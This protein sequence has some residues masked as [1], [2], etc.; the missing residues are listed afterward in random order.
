MVVAGCSPSPSCANA[1]WGYPAPENA[2]SEPMP[3]SPPA[4]LLLAPFRNEA[5]N[6]TDFLPALVE[7]DYPTDCLTVVLIDDGSTDHSLTI[8]RQWTTSRDNW[9]WLSLANNVGKAAALNDALAQF[10]TGEIIV[11]YDAD[12]RP[13]PD[14]LKQLVRSLTAESVGAVTGRRVISNARH[15]LTTSYVAFESLLHQQITLTAKDRLNV[16]PAILGSNCAYRRDALAQ[17]GYFQPGA[18]LEDTDLTLKLTLA[19]WRTR[20]VAEAVSYHQ[21]PT[22][23]AGY[24]R[25]HT[26]WARGFNEVAQRQT[27][28][29]LFCSQLSWGLRL[30]LLTFALGYLDRAVLGIGWLCW[31]LHS[32]KSRLK[33]GLTILLGFSLLTP[34]LQIIAALAISRQP[35]AMWLRLPVV[36]LFFGLDMAMAIWGMGNTIRGAAKVWEERERS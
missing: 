10:V 17:V 16:A 22:T 15:S 31:F 35:L 30:E 6:L 24:W 23:I 8:V 12:E 1:I 4:V 27:P 26:R 2:T 14:S 36:P 21:A 29:L 13:A 34:A 9:H 7:L 18:L 11:I 19:G 20:F 32:Q 25:Q 5:T 3:W 28:T 33:S